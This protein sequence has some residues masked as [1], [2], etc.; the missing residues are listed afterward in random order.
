MSLV[1]RWK[2]ENIN[3][4]AELEAS[5]VSTKIEAALKNRSHFRFLRPY[6]FPWC[7]ERGVA[8]LSLYILYIGF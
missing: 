5:I 4:L 3:K 1:E 6:V 7:R 2:C 8:L